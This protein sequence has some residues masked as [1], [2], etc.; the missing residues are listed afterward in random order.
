MPLP[1]VKYGPNL[2]RIVTAA[3]VG[4]GAYRL[5]RSFWE[6]KKSLS[7]L[8]RAISIRK[9]GALVPYY[10]YKR[11]R[12]SALIIRR[13]PRHATR[14]RSR[15]LTLYKR[16]RYRASRRARRYFGRIRFAKSFRKHRRLGRR[17]YG[18]L[19]RKVR[20]RNRRRRRR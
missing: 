6:A 4:T 7:E 8:N 5:A 15:S 1:I 12:S 11:P 3:S 20:S 9:G 13:R 2:Q 14:F 16:R 17:R 19:A 10:R 18:R